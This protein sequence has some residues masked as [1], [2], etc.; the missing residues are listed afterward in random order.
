MGRSSVFWEL[1]TALTDHI[2]FL[3]CTNESFFKRYIHDSLAVACGAVEA[4]SDRSIDPLS[5]DMTDK[6]LAKKTDS[7]WDIR[8][9]CDFNFPIF[10]ASLLEFLRRDI[11]WCTLAR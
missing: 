1:Y 11:R 6:H 10:D 9:S 7:L 2:D 4:V 3:A 8:L 5:M